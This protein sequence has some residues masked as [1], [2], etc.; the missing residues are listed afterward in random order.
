MLWF[1]S[2]LHLGHKNIIKYSNR[3]FNSVEE[4]DE[5]LINNLNKLVKSDDTLWF[6]GDFCFSNDN[7]LLNYR[8]RINCNTIN[9]VL[10]NHDKVKY[11][12]FKDNF[13]IVCN[14]YELK[15]KEYNLDTDL[16]VLC[17]YA[18][19]VWNRSH[20]GTWHLYGHSHGSLP[21][22]PTSKSFDCGV[23]CFN[24]KP[25]NILEVSDIMSRKNWKTVDHHD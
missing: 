24:Y 9:I 17:H 25:I 18:L 19:K 8:K 15:I 13:N 23:D 22:D 20:H 6:L 10:G 12:S 7:Q 3:P 21:D 4:M 16:V 5:S 14:F 2:D 11:A 1:T